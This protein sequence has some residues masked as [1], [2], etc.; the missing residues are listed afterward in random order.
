MTKRL[1]ID[2]RQSEET[3]VVLLSGTR[4]EDFDYE[5]ENRKQLKGNVYLARVTRVEPSLQAA[6]VEYGGNRQGFLAF[7]EIH[8][9]YYRIPIEDRE[10]LLAADKAEAQD[11][12]NE[13]DA[14]DGLETVGG[15]D[16]DEDDIRP[17]RKVRK[18]KIQE[19]ISRK[20][21]MLVQVVKEERGNKGAALTTYLSLAGRY[22]VLMPNN[23]RGG[24]VS[25]KIT[26]VADRK[27]LKT[28]VGGLDIPDGMAVIVRTAGS[29][30]TK[31][32]IARDYAYLSKLWNDIRERTLE[33]QAPCIIHEEGNLIKRSI[34]DI[35]TSEVEEILVEGEE[36][37]KAARNHIKMLIP[38]HVKKVKKHEDAI[39]LFQ[40]Y[41]VE[42]QMD[43]IHSPQV[44][45]K[46]GGYL[47]INQTEALVAVDVNSGRSTRERNIEETALKTNLEAADEL[48]RQL[49]LRD[50]S[51]LIV[52]DF[53]DMEENRNQNA[54][55]R[56]MKDA[57]RNDRARIQIGSISHFGL[58]EMSRQRL[59]LSIN[60]STSD[61]CPHCEGTGRV[62]SV[63]TAALQTLR[64]IEDEAQKGKMD[65]MHITVHRDIALFILNHKRDA[66][67]ELESRYGITIMLLSDDTLISPEYRI[68]RVGWQGKAPQQQNRRSPKPANNNNN[69]NSN[70]NRADNKDAKNDNASDTA[71]A[72]DS[73]DD[74]QTAS[75]AGDNDATSDE[76][77]PKRRRRGRRG[78]RRRR[79]RNGNE[80]GTNAENEGQTATSDAGSDNVASA[81]AATDAVSTADE[82][83]AK[84]SRGRGRKATSVAT[85]AASA[86]TAEA[87]S[88]DNADTTASDTE[89][90]TKPKRQARK[91]AAPK[92]K[93]D[94]DVTAADDA[95]AKAAPKKAATKKT[96]PKKATKASKKA[97]AA[98][99]DA[100]SETKVVAKKKPRTAAAKKG[101]TKAASKAAASA[102]AATA[103][104]NGSDHEATAADARAPISSAPQDVVDVDGDKPA[105]K[106]RRG[107]WSRG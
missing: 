18:Y 58:L 85:E 77:Q 23:S 78:G 33:S 60:E 84:K 68:E 26:N 82:A 36:A 83:P 64:S 29:K 106:T 45:L 44:T 98:D 63:D 37:Y 43:T 12:D 80:N 30:R 7:S 70:S 32:E 105:G 31:T 39:P 24:G 74:A 71:D 79:R 20:Q 93:A 65:E 15:G 50:L 8:P 59:R 42:S 38:S 96:A 72:S 17:A 99:A 4:I 62:R 57:M 21:I 86:E 6:F 69:N 67:A 16:G 5:T 103:I 75:E 87:Q 107:W 56:R 66:L 95:P 53:I 89:G 22:C 1:L 51:G 11:E 40:H 47:V 10:A 94:I 54:V 81:E 102:D 55:E 27:R 28:V 25:R 13:K 52:V 41:R 76:D 104:S 2:A 88:N 101:T 46:S 61:L 97:S 9:D 92:A 90:E 3:R 91:K 14:E 34:R 48:A 35:Y 49:R 100:V 19:V 73:D